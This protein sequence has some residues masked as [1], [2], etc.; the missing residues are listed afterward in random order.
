VTGVYK[1][2]NPH[3]TLTGHVKYRLIDWCLMPT[4]EVFTFLIW[5]T[6]FLWKY[7]PLQLI[8]KISAGVQLHLYKS[9]SSFPKNCPCQNLVVLLKCQ[10]EKIKCGGKM[11]TDDT[12]R[13]RWCKVMAKAPLVMGQVTFILLLINIGTFFSCHYVTGGHKSH[14]NRGWKG[15]KSYFPWS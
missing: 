14:D 1:N 4:L 15:Q 10:Q 13:E 7:K 8:L 9:D 3:V 11:I 6:F 12:W 2:I 5:K